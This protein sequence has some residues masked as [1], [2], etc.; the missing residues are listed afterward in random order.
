MA[1]PDD[2]PAVVSV[3]A[4][5]VD[6]DGYLE[7]KQEQPFEYDNVPGAEDDDSESG[8]HESGS[9]GDDPTSPGAVR[10]DPAGVPSNEGSS[11]QVEIDNDGSVNLL[12]ASGASGASRN[13][14]SDG[15]QGRTPGRS[16]PRVA[17]R[18]CLPSDNSPSTSSEA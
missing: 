17:P 2:A 7:P 1:D 3:P 8:S 10:S 12:G 15:G 9:G 13:G 18:R 14:G 11:S 16:V 5:G 6:D 4:L